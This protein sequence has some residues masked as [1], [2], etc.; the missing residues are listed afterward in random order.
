MSK[1]VSELTKELDITLQE[2][3][4]YASKM[5][6]EIKS[7]QSSVDDV[8][9]ARLSSTINLMRGNAA[10]SKAGSN[11]PKIKA[12]PVINRDSS[13]ARPGARP[14]IPRKAVVPPKKDEAAADAEVTE[15][16]EVKATKDAEEIKA[17]EAS[18]TVPEKPAEVKTPEPEETA[19]EP[20][21][22]PA[23]K[24]EKA[25][26]AP[27]EKPEE[28]VSADTE[29][30]PEAAQKKPEPAAAVSAAE[31]TAK[32]NTD[33]SKKKDKADPEKAS[34]A[35][36]AEKK[37]TPAPAEEYVNAPG[38]PMRF[39]KISDAATEGSGFF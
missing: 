6:I 30:K 22:E 21:E 35:A 16:A 31:E 19:A 39:K 5:G 26:P 23:Q 9:A 7:A 34:D 20:A 13:K 28:T 10:D 14:V 29:D 1:K 38:K 17:P 33:S 25:E 2:L 15:T 36:A 27:A 24:E 4:D 18:E 11:K 32:K 12:T 8:D 3:K 37:E